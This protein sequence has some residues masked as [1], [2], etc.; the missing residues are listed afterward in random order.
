MMITEC[1]K[2]KM[3][4]GHKPKASGTN[5]DP[6]VPPTTESDAPI[7]NDQGSYKVDPVTQSLRE[8]A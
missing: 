8:V 1:Y 4:A 6:F 7:L 5:R 3:L 2:Q